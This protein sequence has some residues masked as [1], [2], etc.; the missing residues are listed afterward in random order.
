MAKKAWFTVQ[1][2]SLKSQVEIAKERITE[3]EKGPATFS[4]EDYADGYF[5]CMTKYAMLSKTQRRI[6]RDNMKIH[7]PS[8]NRNFNSSSRRFRAVNS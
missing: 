5:D 4:R 3:L 2:E 7:G 8:Y 6:I 1:I